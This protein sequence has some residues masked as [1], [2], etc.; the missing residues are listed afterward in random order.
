MK[1][2]IK[3]SIAI[4]LMASLVIGS[5]NNTLVK[6]QKK[7]VMTKSAKVSVGQKF[8]IKLKNNKN[9]VK[10]KVTNGQKF[11]KITQKS[12]MSCT[13]KA[14]KKGNAMVQATVKGKKYKCKVTVVQPKK[15]KKTKAPE[16]TNNPMITKAPEITNIP[17]T[18]ATVETT[19]EPTMV[20]TEEPTKEPITVP[21]EKPTAEPTMTPTEEPTVEPTIRPTAVSTEEP[22]EEPTAEPTMVP[23]EEPTKEPITVPT[24]EPTVEPTIEP[25][26]NPDGIIEFVYGDDDID[27]IINCT[28]P[29]SLKINEGVETIYYDSFEDLFNTNMVS[30]TIPASVTNIENGALSHC[31]NLKTIIIDEKNTV[32]DSRDNCNAVI[33]TATNELVAGCAGTIIPQSVTKISDGAFGGCKLLTSM[34][35]PKSVKVIADGAFQGCSNLQDIKLSEGVIEIGVWT[36]SGCKSLVN[37]EIP[38]SVERINECAF[39]GCSSLTNINVSENNKIY[40]SRD[41]CN[42]I[43]KTSENE[44]VTGCNNTVIPAN[45]K[46]IGNY[47]FENCTE[48][49]NIQIPDSVTSI[50]FAAFKG[51]SNLKDIELP[52]GITKIG[53][54]AFQQCTGITRIELPKN[55]KELG[56]CA[57][58]ECCSLQSINIPSSV[59][60]IGEGAFSECSN[61]T[62]ITWN[63]NTYN[64][65][66]EF[67]GAFNNK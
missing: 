52:S 12:K 24:E 61:L 42:G 27:D 11:V 39:S 30:V 15:T 45:V 64:S 46:K 5:T 40:D 18:T 6:A 65:V 54:A 9:K 22:T 28:E 19:V 13:I 20:P 63:E 14:V 8:V 67:L 23:T 59:T 29:F 4:V 60:V 58:L 33:K 47:A 34:E 37:I 51:C 57:F 41:N 53:D 35:I 17:E 7:I 62:A 38:A 50:G 25:T 26:K 31:K 36:F 55:V 10:W 66:D 49:V 32:Y 2:N 3:K 43:V 44:L 1:K 21:T 16:N 48:L 56:E